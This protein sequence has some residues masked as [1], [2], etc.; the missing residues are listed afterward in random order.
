MSIVNADPHFL[1]AMVQSY[2]RWTGIPLF[3]ASSAL[4]NVL[5]TK[6]MMEPTALEQLLWQAPHALVA[7]GA[8]P[9][10]IFCYANEKALV[11]FG[12]TPDE[13][14]S[15]PSRYSAEM[16]NRAERAVLLKQVEQFGFAHG[17]SGVRISKEGQRFMIEDATVWNVVD[18]DNRYIG[19]AA[20]IRGH[21]CFI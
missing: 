1:A 14:L 20:L 8:E 2:Q 10:P 12:Y 13:F 7:H 17:Y 21:K 5:L 15:L 19:Q 18:G 3:D 16:D 9:D 4:E 11:L 6:P